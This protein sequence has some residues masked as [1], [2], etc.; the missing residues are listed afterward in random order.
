MKKA[1]ILLIEDDLNVQNIN[2]VALELD[3]YL[4]LEADTL[5]KGRMIAEE[6]A[7]GLIL[8]DILLPDG[9]GL[10]YCEELRGKSGI[11]ILFLSALNTKADVLNGLRAGGDDYIPKP[12]DMD[13]LILRVAALLRRGKMSGM[14]EPPLVLGKLVLN[15]TSNRALLEGRDILLTP[16]EFALI[17]ILASRPCITIPTAELFEK[18]WGMDMVSDT[19]A[20]REHFFRIRDKLSRESGFSI[21]SER[22][23]GYRLDF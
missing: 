23:K 11:R 1:T 9:N 16:K 10:N 21:V 15:H 14:E 18:V 7:P 13:E 22:G 20:V 17:S 12:Y 8:L 2:R 5:K 3:G 19:H 4:I 6:S